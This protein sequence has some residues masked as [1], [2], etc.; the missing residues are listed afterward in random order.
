MRPAEGAVASDGARV[1][2][3]EPTPAVSTD[4]RVIV[5]LLRSLRARQWAKNLLVF[6]APGAAG[7]LTD[8]SVLVDA[9]VAF[10]LFCAAASGVYLVNDVADRSADRLHPRKQLRPIAAGHVPVATAL[11]VA[12]FLLAAS[13]GVGWLA[14]GWRFALVLGLYVVLSVAYSIRLKQIA[15]IDL[16]TVASGFVLRAIAGGVAV[17]VRI[18]SWFLIVTSF[19][20]LF[21]VA[22]KRHAESVDLG[23]A[24]GEHRLTLAEYSTAYLHYVRFTASAVTILAYCLWAFEGAEGG[25]ALWLELSIVPFVLA[26]FRYA[27]LLEAGF[28]DQP[29][30]LL[31]LDRALQVLG[32]AWAALFA[33]GVYAG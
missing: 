33:A 16:A 28:G 25:G 3:T 27:L 13:V 8:G 19:G 26:I 20:S 11:I 4:D 9:V 1:A 15:I 30:E 24:R 18:S 12:S 10:V 21:V 22:G 31:L 17:D 32:V 14:L 2:H 5:G 29:E 7:V 6:A 23:D